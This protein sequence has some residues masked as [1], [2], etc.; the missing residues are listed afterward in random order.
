M[1]RLLR[2][3]SCVGSRA[4]TV[5]SLDGNLVALNGSEDIATVLDCITKGQFVEARDRIEA[6]H[7]VHVG[8]RRL[9]LLE[10]RPRNFAELVLYQRRLKEISLKILI[11]RDFWQLQDFNDAELNTSFGVQNFYF[12]NLKWSQQLW[13]SFQLFVERWFPLSEHT[14]LTYDEYIS[15][16][17]SFAHHENGV[18]MLPV[19]PKKVR[20]HPSF[21]VEAHARLQREPLVLLQSWIRAFRSP[22]MLN[23]ALVV[24]GGGGLTAFATKSAGISMVRMTDPRFSAVESARQDARRMG[25]VFEGMSFHTAAMFPEDDTSTKHKYDVIV[26]YPDQHLLQ[27]FGADEYAFAPGLKG[28]CGDLEIFFDQASRFLSPQGVIVICCTN[29]SSVANP[30]APHPIEYEVKHNRRWVILDYYDRAISQKSTAK[31]DSIGVHHVPLV[32]EMRRSLK[33]ELWVLHPTERLANFA[34]IHKIPGAEIPG[35]VTSKWRHKGLSSYRRRMMKEHVELMGGDW[36][37]YQQ[38]MLRVLQEQPGEDEDDV[39]AEIRM[40][41]D[42]SYPEVL[43]K[44]ARDTIESQQTEIRQFHDVVRTEFDGDISP[45]MVFD[46]WAKKL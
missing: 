19:L 33:S 37:E 39:T 15:L 3:S 17:V 28:M 12:D 8:V 31:G 43:A 46:T 20:L 41:L 36:G 22:L 1:R 25:R 27:G 9:L 4:L 35:A 23:K 11:R 5:R 30:A 14:H 24:R 13:K 44:R 7:N 6:I 21:G 38:R 34:H 2:V 40:S 16:I 45:R 29:F 32:G 10:L 18:R 26:Y 42:P